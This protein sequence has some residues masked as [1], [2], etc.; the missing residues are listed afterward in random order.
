MP[1]GRKI[2]ALRVLME[3]RGIDAYIIPSGDAHASEYTADYWQSRRW[4]SGFTGSAGVVVVTRH[5]AGLWTDGR[6]FLQA[7]REL[8][9]SGIMLY[10]SGEQNVPTYQAF[11][12]EKIPAGGT[13]GFDGR[14]LTA[15]EFKQI[16]SAL[17]N[18]PKIN[19]TQSAGFL[20]QCEEGKPPR[21]GGTQGFSDEAVR[22]KDKECVKFIDGQFLK[23]KTPVFSYKDDLI[24]KL[25]KNRPQIP[26]E[27]AF[28]HAPA[29]AGKSAAAKLDAVREKM[30]EKKITAYLVTALDCV[31]WLLNLRGRDI[32]NFPVI[33]AY[34][35]VTETEAYIFADFIKIAEV[36]GKLTAMGFTIHEYDALPEFLQ[37]LKTG[38][39]YYNALY[40]N[41][42]L[43]ESVPK[44]CDAKNALKPAEDI[45]PLLKCTKTK[46]EIENVK[47]AYIRESLVI[48][49][50]LKWLDE[51]IGK[52]PI[53]E[54]DVSRY[55]TNLRQGLPRY[56][57]D[58]FNTIAAYG[59][60]AALSHYN[61]GETGETLQQSG[62]MLI[63]TGGNYLD[64]T[65]D[66]T[67]T[68]CLGDISDEM[69][70]DFTLVLKG[71]IA[72]SRAVFPKGTT[73]SALDVIA[74]QPLWFD[75]QNYN[76]GT[77]HGIGYCLNVHEGP[78]NIAQHHNPVALA[79]GMLVTNEPGIYKKGRY[80]IRTENVLLV[81]KCRSSP[82]AGNTELDAT[83][84]FLEFEVL[85]FCPFDQRAIMPEKLTQI[86]RDWLNAYH[87][88]TYKTLSPH[89]NNEER[90]WLKNAT[91][92]L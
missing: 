41:V 81:R 24:G 80:G 69:K 72:L 2:A 25:W 17:R 37:N 66:T 47:T 42:L 75:F 36:S 3:E 78:H 28:E 74:R 65:T 59:E 9:G 5:E 71:N 39:L 46:E 67:R 29:F 18:C 33:Y 57:C 30:K 23:E 84:I 34:V 40:T 8:A 7:E 77:G 21:A 90:D 83:G 10:K 73:G 20:S 76:H 60:N 14:I 55:I 4:L 64:G 16:K 92:P 13:I 62:F 27:K 15:S 82:G 91:R 63:D 22:Q 1:A 88:K 56:L 54:A 70:N 79:P 89:L 51:T 87:E 31:A 53:T 44:N 26:T 38:K 58:S 49:K 32:S 61:P 68:V 85:T 35:L 19:F 48:V 11:L 86:E 50:T 52:Q 6:Y 45:I 12:A 43:A